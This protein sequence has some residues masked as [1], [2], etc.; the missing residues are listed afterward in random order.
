MTPSYD[1]TPIGFVSSSRAT[2]T[3]DDWDN[4]SSAI[5]LDEGQFDADSFAGLETF[6]HVE[7]LFLFHQVKSDTIHTGKRRPRGN[8]DWPEV[9]IFA[10]RV[11]NRPNRIG[12]TTCRVLSVSGTRL[13]VQGLDAIDGTPVLDIKPVMKG[14]EP[15]G[16]IR[17]PDWAS[18]IMGDYWKLGG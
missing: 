3:D 2:P 12:A 14:F 13:E 15:R 9:G 5:E 17:E 11:K 1:V 10:Q 16:E 7:I 8:K 6:S 18:A 4:V